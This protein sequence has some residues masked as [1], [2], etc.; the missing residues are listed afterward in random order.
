M[1]T[2]TT[3]VT[4]AQLMELLQ[5]TLPQSDL[6]SVPS[7]TLNSYIQHAVFLR[8]SSPYCRDIPMDMFLHFVFYPRINTED[9]V[10]CRLF[11]YEQLKDRIYG[12]NAADAAL[13]VNR[14]CAEHVT[15]QAS[16]DRTEN[17]I[18]AYRS[19]IG[20]CGEESTFAVSALR[21]VGIP[22][23]QV[24]VPYWSHCD[25]NHAWVEVWAD[26]KWSYLGACEPEP[27]LNRGWFTDAA[28]RAP[29]AFYRT[30]FKCDTD[31]EP[32]GR[33]GAVHLYSVLK[34]YAQ[35]TQLTVKSSPGAQIRLEV[36]NMAAL[37]FVAGGIAD[38]N[39]IFSLHVGRGSYRIEARSDTAC[40]EAFFVV[41][42][43]PVTVFPEPMASSESI[44][45]ID[46]FSPA[47]VSPLGY[48]LTPEQ[49]ALAKVISAQCAQMRERN[50][51]PDAALSNPD[52][53]LQEL[54]QCA[55]A[56]SGEILSFINV[57]PNEDRDLAYRFLHT[58][59]AKDLRDTTCDTLLHHWN[60]SLPFKGCPHFVSA[61]LN[62]RI[63]ME[64][65]SKWRYADVESFD[66][67]KQTPAEY[68]RML[69]RRCTQDQSHIYPGLTAAPESVSKSSF[70]DSASLKVAFVA[71]LRSKGIP[72]RLSKVDG[73]PEF[74]DGEKWK[75][76]STDR[77][78]ILTLHFDGSIPLIYGVHY[79]LSR[80]EEAGFR[81]LNG[82]DGESVPLVPGNYQLIT[83]NRLP[84]GNQ[85]CRIHRFSIA[86][87]ERKVIP[88]KFR[89]AVPEQMLASARIP[90]FELQTTGGQMLPSSDLLHEK[91][92]LCYL[93]PGQEPTEHILNE[94][95]EAQDRLPKICF[96]LQTRAQMYDSL[97]RKASAA[98]PE[99]RILLDCGNEALHARKM[100]LEPGVF[101][102]M[103]LTDSTH[104]GYFG[105]SGY[106]VGSVDLAIRLS[107][108]L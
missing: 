64:K 42:D 12:K 83:T 31:D 3:D 54:L 106:N 105:T 90:P 88:L 49:E 35:T 47:A 11:F 32:V 43:A 82:W 7:E 92:L 72:A 103:I 96:I 37:R 50:R 108:I 69:F 27:V 104:R 23:R 89:Q 44:M 22:S 8:G 15:Y 59:S 79:S 107:A 80:Q 94:L 40:S 97:L 57:I 78:A 24:Y 67:E 87:D 13:E 70:L 18:T 74:W 84:N 28:A 98:V 48:R 19:G 9:L 52:P 51:I 55:G 73:I 91:T 63:G 99:S 2:K 5:N 81:I 86:A 66:P 30:F 6:I 58:V 45:D 71:A 46:W 25:D 76:A 65:I 4:E 41:G 16:D 100:F 68:Y 95:I 34:H 10:P 56:N 93:N 17:P 85:L 75:C 60:A 102:L 29:M 1:I 38:K 61:V 39:G 53:E 77:S 62:P 14:W 21:S 33:E 36:V 101:P 26:G 20:R